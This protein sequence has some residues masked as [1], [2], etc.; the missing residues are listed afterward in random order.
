MPYHH[1]CL[2][3]TLA[4]IQEHALQDAALVRCELRILTRTLTHTLARTL[5]R[6]LALTLALT[7]TLTRTLTL[8]L[9]LSLTL[10]RRELRTRRRQ[11]L[12]VQAGPMPWT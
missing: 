8:S 12:G 7:R 4:T 1:A 3:T 6:T 5:T 10:P 11:M 2:T 9:T